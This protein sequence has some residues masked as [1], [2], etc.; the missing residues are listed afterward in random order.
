MNLGQWLRWWWSHISCLPPLHIMM[1]KEAEPITA[2][3]VMEVAS[4]RPILPLSHSASTTW[5]FVGNSPHLEIRSIKQLDDWSKQIRESVEVPSRAGGRY[6]TSS[7]RR[8]FRSRGILR[9][10]TGAKWVS[11]SSAWKRPWW[12]EIQGKWNS[13]CPRPS[14]CGWTFGLMTQTVPAAVCEAIQQQLTLEK[15]VSVSCW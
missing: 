6:S 5:S 4:P 14:Q 13:I 8:E 3:P 1:D 9:D 10:R 12:S 2:S 11:F 15:H 7:R